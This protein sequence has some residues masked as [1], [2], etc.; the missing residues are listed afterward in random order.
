MST[1]EDF[2]NESKAVNSITNERDSDCVMLLQESLGLFADAFSIV[3]NAN[4]TNATV[5]KM[6]LL[7]QNFATLKCAV[8]IALRGYYTQSMNLLR[9][10]H[11]NWIAFHYL[12]KRPDKA[13]CWLRSNRKKKP[14]SHSTMMKILEED[15]GNLKKNVKGWYSTLCRFA[16]T[17]AVGV[18]PQI[19]TDLHPNETT[20]NFGSTYNDSLFKVS[21]Y[22]ISL[23]T[24][25][26]L[27]DIS[28][29]IPNTDEWHSKMIEVEEKILEF[30]D[31]ENKKSG[32]CKI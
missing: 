29:W 4:N 11:E 12:S 7:S 6:S 31:Q 9:S 27:S 21:T 10:V 32:Y 26:M 22:A 13:T 18:L 24:G 30:I 17:D 25:I 2:D 1:W 20:I 15:F 14:P 3:E 5:V 23:W 16:H 19:A 8:D 28:A